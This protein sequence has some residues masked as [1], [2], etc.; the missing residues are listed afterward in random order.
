MDLFAQLF[1]V[2][3]TCW[4]DLDEPV[5]IRLHG[6]MGW[7]CPSIPSWELT[8]PRVDD[9]PFPKVGY[10]IV[11]RLR[12]LRCHL[13]KHGGRFERKCLHNGQLTYTPERTPSIPFR[14]KAL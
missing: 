3:G 8:Y 5:A 1:V 7:K 11:P 2:H 14:H 6:I 12:K 4:Q 9:F 10:V 13:F